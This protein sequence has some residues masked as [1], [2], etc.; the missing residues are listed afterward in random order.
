MYSPPEGIF[1][2]IFNTQP[3]A[4]TSYV[5]PNLD[6]PHLWFFQKDVIYSVGELFHAHTVIF[7]T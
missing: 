5:V 2:G 6:L 1:L 3:P 7:A 4:S